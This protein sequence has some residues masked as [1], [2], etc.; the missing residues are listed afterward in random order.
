[1]RKSGS[2]RT[3][4]PPKAKSSSP[5]KAIVYV[6]LAGG[7]DSFNILT[8]GP[9][10]C[11][12]YEEYSKARGVGKSFI[13]LRR[14]EILPINGT[15]ARISQCNT[16]GVNQHLPAYQR[17]FN[18]GSG[19][20][21][22]NMGHL[23]KPVTKSNWLTETRTDLFSHHTMRAESHTV[24]AFR[25]GDGPGVLGRMLDILERQGYGNSLSVDLE[26]EQSSELDPALLQFLRLKFIEGK[27]SFILEACFSSTVW[28]QLSLPFS[29]VNELRVF[30]YI[31]KECESNLKKI[32]DSNSGNDDTTAKG[33]DI[34][35]ALARLRLQE[36][37]AL[38]G[39][40]MKAQ[41]ELTTLNGLDTREYYQD[42]RLRELDLLKPLDENEIV[43][44]GER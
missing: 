42:R 39:T 41:N 12:L 19:V 2:P 20:F 31:L 13:G 15:S 14:D 25:E 34:K 28:Y 8:P 4:T 36:K 26:A 29:K 40:I 3:I 6:N 44:P 10:D 21:F 5:Y 37:A 11:L 35:A 30:E 1:M 38:R 27:D 9:E 23:H 32:E 33:N 17:I 22:A 16:L 18:E 24:D 7:V 43:M